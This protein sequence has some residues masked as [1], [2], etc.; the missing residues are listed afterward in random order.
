MAIVDAYSMLTYSAI[1]YMDLDVFYD[2]R[3]FNCSLILDALY[4]T[5]SIITLKSIIK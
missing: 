5:A 3:F 1:L 2:N 4:N